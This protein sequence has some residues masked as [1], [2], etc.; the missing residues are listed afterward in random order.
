MHPTA[1]FALESAPE[2]LTDPSSESIDI[3]AVAR[4][5]QNA[6]EV[7]ELSNW[8]NTFAVVTGVLGFLALLFA[9]IG[10]MQAKKDDNSFLASTC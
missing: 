6:I 5:E 4:V 8:V 1:L 10:K 7:G 2:S 3:E 9:I